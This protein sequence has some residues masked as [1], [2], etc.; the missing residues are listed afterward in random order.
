MIDGNELVLFKVDYMPSNVF[1]VSVIFRHLAIRVFAKSHD[2]F[3]FYE[4]YLR[5]QVGFARV[6]FR[7]R[8]LVRL[9]GFA[10]YRV[11]QIGVVYVDAKHLL[12]HIFQSHSRSS[13]VIRI[14]RV[15]RLGNAIIDNHQIRVRISVT[16]HTL[17][18]RF[19]QV[20]QMASRYVLVEL[21][22]AAWLL[23]VFFVVYAKVLDILKPNSFQSVQVLEENEIL[24]R[25]QIRAFT[26]LK[27]LESIFKMWFGLA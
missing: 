23:I 8:R 19:A 18:S 4:F 7:R 14:G 1:K 22:Q 3:G 20:A 25:L 6:P 27:I 13:S 15:L 5:E 11:R 21:V 17:S 16:T 12:D 24:I 10:F 9:Q 2:D 26:L